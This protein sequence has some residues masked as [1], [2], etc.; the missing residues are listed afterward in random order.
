MKNKAS[1]RGEYH[2]FDSLLLLYKMGRSP[3]GLCV[4]EFIRDISSTDHL[5]TANEYRLALL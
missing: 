1:D 5:E 3:G 4:A 2:V